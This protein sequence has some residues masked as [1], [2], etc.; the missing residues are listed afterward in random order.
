V[1]V[2]VTLQGLLVRLEAD[3]SVISRHKYVD[4]DRGFAPAC[5]DRMQTVD[6]DGKLVIMD[7]TW[8]S[9]DFPVLEAA[10]RLHY[11]LW[12]AAIPTGSD[13]VEATTL[14]RED[15]ARSLNALKDVYLE[16]SLTMSGG[17]PSPWPITKVYP[18]A[19]TAVGQ[20]PSAESVLNKLI[21]GLEEAAEGEL[22]PEKRSRLKDTASWLG[23]GLRGTAEN[24]LGAVIARSMGLG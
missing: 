14:S 4:H 9:R 24:V 16:V 18:G 1:R 7:D 19:R 11:E 8:K 23:A 5:S 3:S 13:I 15:V 20:W 12:P 6:L 17:D 2:G 10:V 22:D 21:A